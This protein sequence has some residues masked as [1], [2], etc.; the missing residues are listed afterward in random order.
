[1]LC[2]L[3]RGN[4]HGVLANLVFGVVLGHRRFHAVR[5]TPWAYFLDCGFG[6]SQASLHAPSVGRRAL[7]RSFVL[8]ADLLGAKNSACNCYTRIATV[9]IYIYWLIHTISQLSLYNQ[10]NKQTIQIH[11]IYLFRFVP[12]LVLDHVMPCTHHTKAF[13]SSRPW[14]SARPRSSRSSPPAVGN[15]M[16]SPI[17]YSMSGNGRP[18]SASDGLHSTHQVT[19]TSTWRKFLFRDT[20]IQNTAPV[21]TH[22]VPCGIRRCKGNRSL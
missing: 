15:I 21:C 2:F 3:F 8:G 9:Y 1:M 13:G 17:S 7:S 10:S 11:S 5:D 18:P 12:I 20:P 14:D 6:I 4:S 16:S 22:G 19:R